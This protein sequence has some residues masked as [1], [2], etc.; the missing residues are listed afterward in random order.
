MQ[1]LQS[2]R[3]G[4]AK[5]GFARINLLAELGESMS[6]DRRVLPSLIPFAFRL[7]PYGGGRGERLSRSRTRLLD[8][9]FYIGIS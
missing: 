5:D 1:A 8:G 2:E 7:P 6:R 3:V 9:F 4:L